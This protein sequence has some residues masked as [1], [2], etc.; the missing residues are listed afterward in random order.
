M[1]LDWKATRRYWIGVG[2]LHTNSPKKASTRRSAGNK[3]SS[4]IVDFRR[5]S[6]GKR[7]AYGLDLSMPPM[8]EISAMFE[9][10]TKNAGRNGLYEA[11]AAFTGRHIRLATMSSGIES[12]L[13]AIS[14]IQDVLT[15][16]GQTKLE[17]EHVFSAEID[18]FKQALIH[19]NY[20]P[21]TIFRDMIEMAEVINDAQPMATNAYGFKVA[22]PKDIDILI[23]GTSCVDFS[24]NNKHR[25]GIDDGGES[26]DTFN[27]VVTYCEPSQPSIVIIENVVSAPWSTLVSRFEAIGYS[28]TCVLVDTK[29]YYLPQTRQRG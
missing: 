15:S 16:F 14:E 1:C 22:V 10:L 18:P 9:D 23:A 29:D 11:I 17:I 28:A 20:G 8:S 6:P 27:A 24:G 19:G 2:H 13:L 3:A 12:P 7:H 26:G 5:P 25:K 4:R 21:P